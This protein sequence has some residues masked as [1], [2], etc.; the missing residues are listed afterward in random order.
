MIVVQAVGGGSR[1]DW[2]DN[3]T[4]ALCSAGCLMW[5]MNVKWAAAQISHPG[6]WS[7]SAALTNGV[8]S[9]QN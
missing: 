8:I 9:G 2:R 1:R 4:K 7:W 3:V 6:D 5:A